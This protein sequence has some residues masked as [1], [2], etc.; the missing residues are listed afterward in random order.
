MSLVHKVPVT[1]DLYCICYLIGRK[2]WNKGKKL[3][4]PQ[5]QKEL[6]SDKSCQ[7]LKIVFIIFF[8]W[9]PISK[10]NPDVHRC[11]NPGAS[12]SLNVHH[13]PLCCCWESVPELAVLNYHLHANRQWHVTHP[14][15]APTCICSWKQELFLLISLIQESVFTLGLTESS[16]FGSSWVLWGLIWKGQPTLAHVKW[17]QYWGCSHHFSEVLFSAVST[18]SDSSPWLQKPLCFPKPGLIL[19]TLLVSCLLVC[20][21]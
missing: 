20:F 14:D 9:S 15:T 18:S 10:S 16:T 1:Y 2:K 21:S 4:C 7:F 19:H 11:K 12:F 6:S 17:T 3:S 8:S 13:N 5:P